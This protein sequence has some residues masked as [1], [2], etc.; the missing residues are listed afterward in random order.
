MLCHRRILFAS[1]FVSELKKKDRESEK[2]LAGL[3]VKITKV[4]T[5][6]VRDLF[7]RLILLNNN[8]VKRLTH[9]N[10]NHGKIWVM[11]AQ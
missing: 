6:D 8:Y 10:F 5:R 7:K 3:G 1:V 9:I 11:S 4:P 2:L